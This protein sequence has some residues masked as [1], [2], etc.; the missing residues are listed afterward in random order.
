M[1]LLCVDLTT[2][3]SEMCDSTERVS[4]ARTHSRPVPHFPRLITHRRQAFQPDPASSLDPT[5]AIRE[6]VESSPDLTLQ[7]GGISP[8]PVRR[9]CS[10][11]AATTLAA[12]ARANA[13]P[14]HLSTDPRPLRPSAA[15]VWHALHDVTSHTPVSTAAAPHHTQ[16]NT[17][18]R[19]VMSP[20]SAALWPHAEKLDSL[21]HRPRLAE[22]A[23]TGVG[24][25]QLALSELLRLLLIPPPDDPLPSARQACRDLCAR[26]HCPPSRDCAL[27]CQPNPTTP[28]QQRPPPPPAARAV[29]PPPAM[30]STPPDPVSDPRVLLPSADPQAAM[31]GL[32]LA[33]LAEAA[34]C[35]WTD[36]PLAFVLTG[37]GLSGGSGSSNSSA[38]LVA[39]ARSVSRGRP[40]CPS[41]AEAQTTLA[42]PPT[43]YVRMEK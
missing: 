12:A 13:L 20:A 40:G 38:G 8:A 11:N 7:A 19:Q 25:V 41:H 26:W 17:H 21:L 30:A 29:T 24:L 1:A 33:A 9:A 28:S 43:P 36:P 18:D 14:G 6:S 4:L 23:A 35:E 39:G 34:T 27:I 3:D 32:D 15:E 31:L 37:G 42:Q 16:L 5:K 10:G 2:S 22:A